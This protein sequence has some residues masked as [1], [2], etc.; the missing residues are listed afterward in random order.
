MSRLKSKLIHDE[1]SKPDHLKTQVYSPLNTEE[2]TFYV[3]TDKVCT[4]VGELAERTKHL[5]KLLGDADPEVRKTAEEDPSR[6]IRN[7]VIVRDG[8]KFQC[9]TPRDIPKYTGLPIATVT[10][11]YRIT[12]SSAGL[13][14][15]RWALEGAF[16]GI[17]V[18]DPYTGMDLHEVNGFKPSAKQEDAEDKSE[19]WE[20]RLRVMEA[21]DIFY[22][23][24]GEMLVEWEGNTMNDTIADSVLMVLYSVESSPAAVKRK[25]NIVDVIGLSPLTWRRK[26]DSSQL[27]LHT[28]V[29]GAPT[30]NSDPRKAARTKSLP[31]PSPSPQAHNPHTATDPSTSLQR[32]LWFMETQFGVDDIEPILGP[33]SSS[34][35]HGVNGLHPQDDKTIA[36]ANSLGS[37]EW[38]APPIPSEYA[39]KLGTKDGVHVPGLRI[40]CDNHSATVW[41][42]TLEVEG[43]NK[44][45]T[46]R[47]RAVVGRAME[48]IEPL[49]RM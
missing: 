33:H 13:E 8:D 28:Q 37:S 32:F 26:L 4:F 21:V 2:I 30:G 41:L 35:E 5:P 20:Y 42:D 47:V 45:I 16:G 43:T 10:C 1:K 36:I 29:N 46:D 19:S 31:N 3:R 11:K 24:R 22:K 23:N 49:W 6:I 14:L 39:E 25:P 40:K 38:M 7:A 9:M 17:E 27:H 48:C 12:L 44:N 34:A 18:L 15:I